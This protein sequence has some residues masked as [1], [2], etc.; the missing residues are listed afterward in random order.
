[1]FTRFEKAFAGVLLVVCAAA[2]IFISVR[3]S[4]LVKDQ[5]IIF[6]EFHSQL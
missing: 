4:G 2:G 6:N 3:S 5:Q 1:M